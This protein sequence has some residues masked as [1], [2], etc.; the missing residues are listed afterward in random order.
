MAD[1]LIG[2]L[3]PPMLLVPTM[4]ALSRV[5]CRAGIGLELRRKAL[6]V[7]I[8]LTALG[9]PLVFESTA[10]LGLACALALAWMLALGQTPAR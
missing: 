7:S 6:H 5:P 2:L 10:V 1:W 3:F 4:G 8:G 9:F